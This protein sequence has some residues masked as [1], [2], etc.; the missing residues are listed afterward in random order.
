MGKKRFGEGGKK[1]SEG[2]KKR[3]RFKNIGGGLKKGSP[4]A[5]LTCRVG[6]S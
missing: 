6:R 4:I 3:G 5:I 2:V 1:G